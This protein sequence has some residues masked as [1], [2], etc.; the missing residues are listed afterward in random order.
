MSTALPLTGK[1]CLVTGATSGHGL[2]VARALARRGAHLVLLARDAGKAAGVAEALVLEAPGRRR[3]E[4]LLGDLASQAS[5]ARAVEAFLSSG[6][7]LHLLVNN[8]G[9]VSLHRRE[10]PDGLEQVFAVNYLALY[11]LTLGLLPRL[12]DSGTACEPARVVNVSSDMHR[13]ARL[14]LDDLQSRRGYS[15]HGSYARSKL[16]IVLF[17]RELARRLGQPAPVGEA[18]IT[19]NAVDPGPVRSGIAESAPR[20]IARATAWMMRW[21]FPSADQAARTAVFV[22]TAP[23]VASITGAYFRFG[24][25]HRPGVGKDPELGERLWRES[26]ALT[27][28]D[29]E[30]RS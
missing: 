27:G 8:A 15:W 10:T 2:A 7:P 12:L 22:A 3:P 20:W 23:E 26:V 16:A 6:R 14:H 9:I 30:A 18:R 17:T 11:Q 19:V 28:A 5:I 4:V 25:L 29:F 21:F 1:T 24:R 13:V